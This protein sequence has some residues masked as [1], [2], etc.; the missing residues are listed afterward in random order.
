MGSI[1]RS[2]C[3]VIEPENFV[4]LINGGKRADL[5]MQRHY[6]LIKCFHVIIVSWQEYLI[7]MNKYTV[8]L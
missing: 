2:R 7:S 8:F 3:L 4:N 1:G 6:M 5:W